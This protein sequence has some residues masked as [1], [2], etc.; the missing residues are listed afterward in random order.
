MGVTT[1]KKSTTI[2]TAIFLLGISFSARVA[3]QDTS[4]KDP[5]L[6]RPLDPL[7]SYRRLGRLCET[8]GLQRESP[9]I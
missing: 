8:S 6:R 3:A 5:L 1:M 2:V 9:S 4:P 7:D